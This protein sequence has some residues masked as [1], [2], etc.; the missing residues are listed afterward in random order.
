MNLR[1]QL[2][3]VIGS[4]DL[5]RDEALRDDTPLITSGLLDSLALFNLAAWVE[6]QC[7]GAI[8]PATFDVVREWNS[9][10]DVVSFVERRRSR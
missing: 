8:D 9:I 7:G 6:D 1:D 4:W 10:A 3:H 5:A 2:L